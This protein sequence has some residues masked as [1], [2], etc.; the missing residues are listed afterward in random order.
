MFSLNIAYKIDNN[1]FITSNQYWLAI[2]VDRKN[3]IIEVNSGFS[4][5]LSL[6]EF[7]IVLFCYTVS[8]G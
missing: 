8:V 4:S 7:C 2:Q 5:T 1:K 3:N 6:N